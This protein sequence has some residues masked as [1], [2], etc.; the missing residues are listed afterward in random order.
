MTATAF[1][2][3]AEPPQQRDHDDPGRDE[4]PLPG[5]AQLLAAIAGHLRHGSSLIEWA[6]ELGDLHAALIPVRQNRR[7]LPADFDEACVHIGIAEIIGAI[8]SWA[9][10]HVPKAP[11]AR[12]HTHSLGEV[13]SHIA[14]TYAHAWWAVLHVSDKDLRHEAWLHLGEVCEGYA[15]L[16]HD[17]QAHGVR[18]PLGWRGMRHTPPA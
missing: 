14:Q 3:R 11:G 10:V 8:D 2:C 1:R 7:R 4:A 5:P 13:I 15:Q 17:V 12:R 6:R 18:F 16:I 9:T